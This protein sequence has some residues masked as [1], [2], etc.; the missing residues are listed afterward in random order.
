MYVKY[1]NGKYN[2]SV[3]VRDEGKFNYVNMTEKCYCKILTVCGTFHK[4]PKASHNLSN[5]RSFVLNRTTGCFIINEVFECF[6]VKHCIKQ[7]DD[8]EFFKGLEIL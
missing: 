1:L 8:A 7:S 4:P 6:E 3:Y 2:V 5:I